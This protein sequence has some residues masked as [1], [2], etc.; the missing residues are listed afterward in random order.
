MLQNI[1]EDAM[2]RWIPQWIIFRIDIHVYIISVGKYLS[3]KISIMFRAG[4]RLVGGPW[5]DSSC[6]GGGGAK[7]TYVYIWIN[8][9][10]SLE[11]CIILTSDI[12]KQPQTS[13]ESWGQIEG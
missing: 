7:H 1:Y 2:L 4:F 9:H 12:S 6:G 3:C 11:K 13:L 8:F 5:A 10:K